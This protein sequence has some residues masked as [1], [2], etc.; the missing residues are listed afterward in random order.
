MFRKTLLSVYPSM[1]CIVAVALAFTAYRSSLSR[2]PYKQ[3]RAPIPSSLGLQEKLIAT[4][5]AENVRRRLEFPGIVQAMPART[6]DILS[7]VVGRLSEVKVQLGDRVSEKQEIAV[8]VTDDNVADP[9]NLQ[10]NK[11]IAITLQSP[12]AGSI[13]AL[14][15]KQG[16]FVKRGSSVASVSDLKVV[17]VTFDLSKRKMP[18][19]AEKT[20]EIVFLAYPEAVF[21][22]EL[23]LDEN[24]DPAGRVVL[25]N[26]EFRIKPN[27][28]AIVTLLGPKELA[29]VVPKTALVH[30]DGVVSI[31]VEV[32]VCRFE[33]RPVEV[34]F[35]QGAR[36]I[37]TRGLLPGDRVLAASV[38]SPDD[39]RLRWNVDAVGRRDSHQLVLQDCTS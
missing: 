21:R 24:E 37:V 32:A 5:R 20:A 7:P 30:K 39:P 27:M 38:A 3:G 12:I 10:G 1:A 25:N 36:A 2:E 19:I 22:G 9:T 15:S 11:R 29:T 13:I 33:L 4:V 35:Q 14:Q 8:I 23:Q 31:Y 34:A 26:P 16:D 17:R 18:L 28:S 6:L